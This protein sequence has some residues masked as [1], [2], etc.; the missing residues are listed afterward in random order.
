MQYRYTEGTDDRLGLYG[1]IQYDFS[2]DVRLTVDALHTDREG[3]DRRGFLQIVNTNNRN[4]QFD[5]ATAQVDEN[6]V[7]TFVD[8]A[9]VGPV[10]IQMQDL[11][12][13]DVSSFVGAHVDWSVGAWELDFDTHYSETTRDRV[14][15]QPRAQLATGDIPLSLSF[16]D[17]GLTSV[18][19]NPD[20]GSINDYVLQNLSLIHI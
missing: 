14:L 6:N 12:Q 1:T 18:V 17:D 5:A 19:G 7:L 2:P 13:E 3:V 4:S 8:Y 9:D 16:S 10:R 11:T 20:F 15:F